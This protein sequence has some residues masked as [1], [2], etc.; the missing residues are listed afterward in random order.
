VSLNSIDVSKASPTPRLRITAGV[1]EAMISHCQAETPLEACGL[2]SGRGNLAMACYRFRNAL[3]SEV[4]YDVAPDEL[5]QV[6]Q[7]LRERRE[8]IVALYHSHPRWQAVPSKTDLR[9]NHWGEMPRIIV[10]LL[11]EEP[12]VRIW[13]LTEDNYTEI[14]WEL[15]AGNEI[16]T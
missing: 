3:R 6:I 1:L 9:E 7:Q 5:I 15:I 8:D 4:K 16:T 12:V 11:D 13:R 2:L 14:P 10:S